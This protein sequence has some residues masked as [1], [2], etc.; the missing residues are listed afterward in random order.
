[1]L[2]SVTL[3]FCTNSYEK[4]VL[5]WQKYNQT[6]IKIRNNVKYDMITTM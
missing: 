2:S 6:A 1:M 5:T 4:S 3:P